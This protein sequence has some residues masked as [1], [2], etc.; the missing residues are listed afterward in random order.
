[1]NTN[2]T[3]TQDEFR[4]EANLNSNFLGNHIGRPMIGI[5]KNKIIFDD[6]MDTKRE[7]PISDAIQ[8]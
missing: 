2:G 3:P 1:M 5:S 6:S 8:N 7:I 4:A